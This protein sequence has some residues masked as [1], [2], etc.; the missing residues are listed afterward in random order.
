MRLT[1]CEKHT[2]KRK[3]NGTGES[4]NEL[5]RPQGETI[6]DKKRKRKIHSFI[7]AVNLSE[8]VSVWG[9]HT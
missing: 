7:H 6:T 9:S 8:L 3:D 5:L 4:E 1:Q 2:I